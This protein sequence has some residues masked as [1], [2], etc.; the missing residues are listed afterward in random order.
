M[1]NEGFK[2]TKDF[3]LKG[4]Y[5]YHPKS[6][7]ELIS[8]LKTL[9]DER[10]PNADLNDIDTSNVRDMSTLFPTVDKD[11]HKNNISEWNVINVTNMDTMF[12]NT[13]ITTLDLSKWNVR[14][15]ESMRGMFFKCKYLQNTGNLNDWK[16]DKV[17]DMSF[18]FNDCKNL[19]NIGD[20]SSWDI[21]NK[22]MEYAFAGTE[23]LKTIGDIKH[24][25]PKDLIPNIFSRSE[26][27]P[28]PDR[29]VR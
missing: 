5:K 27:K 28:Q 3:K 16:V 10:G 23:K 6:H 2:I 8:L 12:Y 1:I 25:K 14:K 15:V 24:W 13:D 7:I 9:L 19:R 26:I 4:K 18:M 17:E 21:D 29:W 22:N 11:I 20:I